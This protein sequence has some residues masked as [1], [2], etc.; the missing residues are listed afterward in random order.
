MSETALPETLLTWAVLA[1]EATPTRIT[2]LPGWAVASI[3]GS[4]AIVL[5]NPEEQGG[6]LSL[7]ACG[8]IEGVLEQEAA[9]GRVPMLVLSGGSVTDT[10]LLAGLEAWRHLIRRLHQTPTLVVVV[11]AVTGVAALVVEA[12]AWA[13]RCAPTM[14]HDGAQI[15]FAE[16]ALPISADTTGTPTAFAL[17]EAGRV[18][19]VLSAPRIS[20][21]ASPVRL[22]GLPE[23]GDPERLSDLSAWFERVVDGGAVLPLSW[24][25][26]SNAV[27]AALARINGVLWLSAATNGLSAGGSL[28]VRELQVLECLMR[29]GDRLGIPV[30]V[31]SDGPGLRAEADQ[32]DLLRASA[33]SAR[34]SLS[35]TLNLHL[36]DLSPL[37]TGLEVLFPGAQQWTPPAGQDLALAIRSALSNT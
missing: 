32:D 24:R 25:H 28:G 11:G 10:D 19:R 29:A 13:W 7:A 1:L 36:I 35:S 8:M 31:L 5:Q 22:D 3:E 6:A 14:L 9:A 20:A 27:T 15:D 16:A 4:P 17:S 33:S 2:R 23:P 21:S 34:L 26:S 37:P 12:A 18:S 30:L